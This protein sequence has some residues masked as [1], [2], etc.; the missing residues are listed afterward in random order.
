[1]E[2]RINEN[3]KKGKGKGRNEN[4]KN[5]KGKGRKMGTKAVLHTSTVIP[6][7]SNTRVQ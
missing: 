5:G 4:W 3:G 6:E 7:Y 1:M 2:K